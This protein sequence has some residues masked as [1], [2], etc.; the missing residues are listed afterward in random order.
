MTKQKAAGTISITKEEAD[1][2]YI[3]L[4][5]VRAWL[6]GF[7]AARQGGQGIGIIAGPPGADSLRQVQNMLK[8]VK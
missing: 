1:R 4:G 5:K 6:S 3:E 7:A 2:L 8:D